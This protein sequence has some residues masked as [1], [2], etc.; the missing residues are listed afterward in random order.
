M[1]TSPKRL[2]VPVWLTVE[3]S[4]FRLSLV[5]PYGVCPLR[6]RY[7]Y[8]L[9]ASCHMEKMFRVNVKG[10][11]YSDPHEGRST[12]TNLVRGRVLRTCHRPDD[13]N[14]SAPTILL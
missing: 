8:V 1:G 6:F 5:S 10:G 14:H 4:I 7:T 2:E 9:S 3:E 11:K 12:S 13:V